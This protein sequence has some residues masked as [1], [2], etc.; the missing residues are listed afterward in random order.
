[1]LKDATVGDPISGLKWAHKSPRKLVKALRRQGLKASHETV[2]RLLEKLGY[3]LKVNRK[4]LGK[5]QDAER[6]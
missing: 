6:D 4:R 1:L 2:R 5:R 3:S